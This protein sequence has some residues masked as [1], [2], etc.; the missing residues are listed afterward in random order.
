MR[1]NPETLE[2]AEG[3]AATQADLWGERARDWADVLERWSGWGI[4]ICPHVLE[5]V[6]VGTG[7]RLL[8]VG[9]GAGRFC[10][11][12]ADPG[13]Q[14]AGL[15]A[16]AALIR[17][18]GSAS[19]TATIASATW[20]CLP[21]GDDS[22]AVVTGFNSFFYAADR[23]GRC[24]RRGASRAPGEPRDHSL[25]PA[26]R[27]ESTPV[28][29]S[30]GQSVDEEGPALH[31]EGVLEALVTEAGLTP[32]EA[33]YCEVPGESTE[34][35]TILRGYLAAGPIVRSVR[36]LGEQAVRDAFSEALRPLRTSTGG[37]RMEDELR[38]LI[39]VA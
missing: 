7:T 11:I 2:R 19:R 6:P 18:R 26:E 30:L 15:D 39:A 31:E 24:A 25:R 16:T 37:V 36:A 1:G 17:S 10:R 21:C 35:D 4:P 14:I 22:F 34:L 23:R 20:S 27:R 29:G 5:R 12:A 9:R 33:G 13:A 32:K 28:L 38:Y 8:D 3:S